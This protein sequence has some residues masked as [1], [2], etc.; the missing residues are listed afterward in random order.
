MDAQIEL[1]EFIS[2]SADA[3]SYDDGIW[4][5]R[6]AIGSRSS[7]WIRPQGRRGNETG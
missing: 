2:R 5:E 3:F 4:F 1:N 6:R 7:K